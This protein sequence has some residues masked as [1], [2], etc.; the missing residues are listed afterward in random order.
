ML[1]SGF[2][3][4]A[5]PSANGY[6]NGIYDPIEVPSEYYSTNDWLSDLEGD[7]NVLW[8]PTSPG[9][10]TDWTDNMVANLDNMYTGKPD[11]GGTTLYG[12]YYRSFLSQTLAE[13][14]T[15]HFG[16]LLAPSGI[17]Y[18]IIREDIPSLN[19]LVRDMEASLTWQQDMNL[20]REDGALKVY[21]VR[22]ATA[23][24][25]VTSNIIS[26]MG[27]LDVLRSLNGMNDFDVSTAGVVFP[28][29]TL[30]SPLLESTWVISDARQEDLVLLAGKGDVLTPYDATDHH[31]PKN[32]WSKASTLDPLHGTWR[33]Y[34]EE[35]NIDGWYHDYGQG[36]VLTW[37]NGTE[38]GAT[39]K[40][41]FSVSQA[42]QY[43]FSCRFL[44]TVQ[45]G[46]LTLRVDD[47]VLTDIDTVSGTNGFEWETVEPTYLTAGEHVL[48]V[49]NQYGLNALNLV[50]MTN[51]TEWEGAWGSAVSLL[52]GSPVAY[53]WEAAPMMPTIDGLDVV[54]SGQSS[55][56]NAV[57]VSPE[58][59][60]TT[61][62]DVL[63][64]GEFRLAVEGRGDLALIIDDE[65]W[66]VNGS[67]PGLA[68]PG[69]VHLTAGK[70]SL[71]VVNTG[72][73]DAI[74]DT[75]WLYSGPEPTLEAF[76]DQGSTAIA[77][78]SVDT[79]DPTSYPIE[80][81]EDGQ[82]MLVTGIV[83]Y[84]D[85]VV[86]VD[87]QEIPSMPAWGH[88]N[89]FVLNESGPVSIVVE[90]RPQAWLGTGAVISVLGTLILIPLLL[91]VDRRIRR[92][93]E[94]VS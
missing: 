4:F 91:V 60:V 46:T 67:S 71:T 36:A 66:S 14:R 70:H 27:G 74:I 65:S 23:R 29:Q 80:L 75:V 20:V 63:V 47:E 48:S 5:A 41:S 15:D 68:Y 13:N 28:Q 54:W 85:W 79:S 87:G 21:E 40:L 19:T 55:Q 94:K 35:W 69:S 38:S 6:L 84:E 30:G 31:D 88:L 24:S 76:L 45:G 58:Q 26:V 77:V 51:Q 25:F 50:M 72:T 39:I 86:L 16:Q 37:A 53:L 9:L 49:T 2:A 93:H 43:R 7:F 18:L 90:Y 10:P 57:A 78:T 92:E 56:G 61:T 11:L 3:V 44:R 73:E 59:E 12:A 1:L 81:V 89:A 62:L 64:E 42:D 33:E 34:L 8:L 83:Y 32:R 22:E 17:K 52:S 82:A